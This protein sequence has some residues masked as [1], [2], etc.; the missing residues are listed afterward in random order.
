MSED[1]T[2]NYREAFEKRQKIWQGTKRAPGADQEL[3]LFFFCV[4]QDQNNGSE[5]KGTAAAR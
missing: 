1:E 5:S 4:G 3:G 2:K